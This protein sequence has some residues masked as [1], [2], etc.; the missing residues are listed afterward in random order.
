MRK[1]WAQAQGLNKPDK[2][3]KAINIDK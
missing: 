2:S 1:A 3:N